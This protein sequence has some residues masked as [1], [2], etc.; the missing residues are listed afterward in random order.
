MLLGMNEAAIAPDQQ[1]LANE[2]LEQTRLL[3]VVRRN[4]SLPTRAE[5]AVRVL[6]LMGLAQIYIG[7]QF[8][9]HSESIHWVV[10]VAGG[11][12]LYCIPIDRSSSAKRTDALVDFL[13]RTGRLEVADNRRE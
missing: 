5:V 11:V 2:L 6:R 1:E 3:E 12:F 9:A 8:V 13:D 4:R 7:I 10:L